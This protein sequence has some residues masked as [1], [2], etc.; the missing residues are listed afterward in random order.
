MG[1]SGLEDYLQYAP[2]ASLIFALTVFSSV[3]ALT[4]DGSLI[5]RF[6]LHPCSVVKHHQYH[7]V[8]TSAFIHGSW[9]HL[10][11]NLITYYFFVFILETTI[12]HWQ[13]AVIYIGS[14]IAGNL[15]P[16][17]RNRNNP[18]YYALGASGAIS[19]A[20]FSMILYLIHNPYA[21][22]L[23]FFVIPIPTWLFPILY[24]AYSYWAFK[25]S[26]DNIGHDAHLWGAITGFVLTLILDPDTGRRLI[27]FI[28]E[29]FNA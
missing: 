27:L 23:L 5:D 15:S 29:R 13:F 4:V 9:M 20:L 24:I 3:W 17:I 6:I 11:V 21:Q 14:L 25:N 19:G 16:I 28:S 10:I 8:I 18:D 2:V 12:G 26:R 7:R 22:I 1:F